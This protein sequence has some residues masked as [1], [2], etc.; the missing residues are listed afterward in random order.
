MARQNIRLRNWRDKVDYHFGL[1]VLPSTGY[2]MTF[3]A[4]V[5]ISIQLSADDTFL[6]VAWTLLV[7]VDSITWEAN[8]ELV[9]LF[10]LA[11]C[12]ALVFIDF[13]SH[14]DRRLL[15][16][17]ARACRSK[18]QLADYDIGSC[19]FLLVA[20]LHPSLLFLNFQRVSGGF[21]WFPQGF[22]RVSKVSAGFSHICFCG[23]CMDFCM[24][25]AEFRRF[26]A[27]FFPGLVCTAGFFGWSFAWKV[28]RTLSL[29]KLRSVAPNLISSKYHFWSQ[30]KLKFR[31]AWEWDALLHVWKLRNFWDSELC[32]NLPVAFRHVV[33]LDRSFYGLFDT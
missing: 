9:F 5:N 7:L 16:D 21:L 27:V 6:S 12:T 3:T 26:R 15:S 10:R 1:T 2:E 19:S 11:F 33:Q 25:C 28:C 14:S 4:V 31:A 8:W 22:R 24:V 18:K 30:K 29:Q 13:H 20:G 23:F 32:G 17:V